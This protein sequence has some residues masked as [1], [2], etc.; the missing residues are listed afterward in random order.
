MRRAGFIAFLVLLAG[1]L[2]ACSRSSDP[3]PTIGPS[4][5]FTPAPATAI[6]TPPSPTA[7]L[8]TP[9]PSSTAVL[10]PPGPM[11]T[12][13]PVPIPSTPIP[14]TGVRYGGTLNL[15]SRENIVHQD[16]HQEV[17]PA[18]STWGPGVAYSRLLRFNSGPGVELPTL[19]VE[20]E[21][22]ES[23]TMED[24]I[25]YI[26]QL[27]GDVRWQ[28]IS[29]VNGRGLTADDL[30]FSYDRQRRPGLPNAPLLQAIQGMEAVQP[31][32]LRISLAN[33]D[34]DFLVALADGHSKIVARE[35]VELNGDLMNG[36]TIGTGPWVLTRTL[37]DVS[38]TFEINPRYFQEGLPFVEKLVMHIITDPA[39]RNAAFR[40][41]AIDVHQMEP[42][43]WEEYR[44]QNPGAPFLMTRDAGTGLEVA[45]KTTVPPFDDV[46]VRR[47]AFQ[48]MDPWRAIQDLWLGAA[49]VSPG[50]PLGEAGWLLQETELRDYFG[51]PVF[52][53]DLLLEAGVG[54]PL[55][56]SIK[57]GDFG[58]PYLAHAQRIADEMRSV[59]FE[60]ALEVV[61]RRV[62]GDEIWLGGDYQMF[63]GP[64]APV[65]T[66]NGYLLSVL[67]SQGQW[68]TTE[69]RDEELDRLI[70]AQAQEFDPAVRK[71]LIQEIQR[72]VLDSA[73]RFMP[74]TQV[75]IWTWLPRVQNFHPN[76]AG[77]GYSH[78][79]NVWLKE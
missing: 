24:A 3:T 44:Q 25:T 66:P 40:V 58:E 32:I 51:R 33:P 30:I 39:T 6:V 16:I 13:T 4:A 68:N 79:A 60:P 53:R 59:G 1:L 26:F 7:I 67:H 57:V 76:F 63:V 36:P 72:R 11:L 18:L 23:W 29:P 46:G 77:F 43:E 54:T 35:A 42:Q 70:E 34:V 17:S 78:W 74:A 15:I 55:P 27:R 9:T 2:A 52:A 49:F 64:T 50:F 45:L 14:I 31:D 61:N 19:A 69:H 62:F 56:F 73:Y 65:A 37:P 48:A 41:G 10:P 8:L 21:L 75:S 28:D 22:C 47:A 12:A 5:T 20:C 71:G 38:H